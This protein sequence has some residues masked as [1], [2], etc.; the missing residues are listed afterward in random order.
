M[1]IANDIADTIGVI[2]MSPAM[3]LPLRYVLFAHTKK[4]KYKGGAHDYQGIFSTIEAARDF[5]ISNIMN[6]HASGIFI[7]G[8]IADIYNNFAIV[9][10]LGQEKD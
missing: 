9:W 8:H 2:N 5:Y 10:V 3:E 1:R 4:T 6:S 7:S